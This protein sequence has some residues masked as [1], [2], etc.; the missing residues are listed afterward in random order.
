MEEFDDKNKKR[1]EQWELRR[2]YWTKDKTTVMGEIGWACI[3]REC[4][5]NTLKL[6]E[7]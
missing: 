6:S 3:K 5:S 7:L 4:V 2:K 1:N